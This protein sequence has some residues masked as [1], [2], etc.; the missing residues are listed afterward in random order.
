MCFH[1]LLHTLISC[2]CS[3]SGR[4]TPSLQ[5]DNNSLLVSI[6]A[7]VRFQVPVEILRVNSTVAGTI[8][9]MYGAS[10][11]TLHSSV[12]ERSI[13]RYACPKMQ[14]PRFLLQLPCVDCHVL[15]AMCRA[16][17]ASIH[18]SLSPH[19]PPCRYK[20]ICN[21]QQSY[22][23]G[24]PVPSYGRCTVG[25]MPPMPLLPGTIRY[26]GNKYLNNSEW[27][28][29]SKLRASGVPWCNVEPESC[30]MCVRTKRG[31]K[32]GGEIPPC[33]GN[34][35][36]KVDKRCHLIYLMC[37]CYLLLLS[38]FHNHPHSTHSHTVP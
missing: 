30:D 28:Y 9:N 33:M 21:P 24:K 36:G 14:S 1:L 26:Y 12:D 20:C 8:T 10:H 19:L 31:K 29:R 25:P 5:A 37:C 15:T 32:R 22:A 6:D 27:R 34:E 16:G 23:D 7:W 3:E 4:D 2:C 35:M 38:F 17:L 11:V 18:F 13:S